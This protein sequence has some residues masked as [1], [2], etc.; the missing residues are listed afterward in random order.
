VTVFLLG[1]EAK[2]LAALGFLR[3]AAATED[4]ELAK[5]AAQNVLA[6]IDFYRANEASILA[7]R[8]G[9]K[10][11]VSRLAEDAGEKAKGGDLYH[12]GIPGL[13]NRPGSRGG[14]L[15]LAAP[16]DRGSGARF[17]IIPRP[18][19][20]RMRAAGSAAVVGRATLLART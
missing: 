11:P 10:K 5:R 17:S 15:P 18:R 1:L 20:P 6:Q 8:M 4:R 19:L 9:R 12:E 16:L 13:T 2:R 7:F 3:K 14:A